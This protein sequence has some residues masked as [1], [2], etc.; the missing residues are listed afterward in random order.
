MKSEQHSLHTAVKSCQCFQTLD[1][2]CES[3]TD[4]EKVKD[5]VDQRQYKENMSTKDNVE[6]FTGLDDLWMELIDITE[7]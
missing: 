4:L 1:E 5:S 3:F 6:E 2:V 7:C